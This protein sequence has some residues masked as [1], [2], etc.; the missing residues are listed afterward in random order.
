MTN[1]VHD[2][3]NECPLLQA[4]GH[5]LP[6]C[7]SGPRQAIKASA[8]RPQAQAWSPHPQSPPRGTY[9]VF[10]K[11]PSVLS[12]SFSVRRQISQARR[13]TLHFMMW[14]GMLEIHMPILNSTGHPHLF[15]QRALHIP[16]SAAGQSCLSKHSFWAMH[17]GARL[18]LKG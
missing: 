3:K 11:G 12:L 2:A 6:K 17:C 10:G 7:S 9:A 13:G 5:A 14:R 16:E 4:H 1:T 18:D 8:R 15:Q